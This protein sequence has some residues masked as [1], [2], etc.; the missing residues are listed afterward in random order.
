MAGPA[1]TA[2]FTATK[3]RSR[4]Y[5]NARNEFFLF[6]W[7]RNN[8]WPDRNPNIKEKDLNEQ[9]YLRLMLTQKAGAL[10]IYVS[11]EC[12]GGGGG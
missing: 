4:N 10:G 6:Y 1:I 9:I 7:F 2:R 5:I 12:G 3:S 11:D 8:E